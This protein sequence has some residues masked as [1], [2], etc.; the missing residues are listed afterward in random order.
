M[1]DRR[2]TGVPSRCARLLGGLG[3]RHDDADRAQVGGLLDRAFQLV[4]HADERHGADVRAGVHHLFDFAPGHRAV[5]H[6]KPSEIVV[7]RLFAVA[8]DVEAR[9]RVA[10]DLLALLQLLLN[11]VDQ[12]G[13]LS[14]RRLGR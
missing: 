7:R 8:V 6:L 4:G 12:R 2:I 5:L 11:L 3:G 9:D 14:C 1:S 13:R 10:E